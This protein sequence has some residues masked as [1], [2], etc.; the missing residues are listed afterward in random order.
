MAFHLYQDMFQIVDEALDGFVFESVGNLIGGIAPLFTSLVVIVCAIWGYR[1]MYGTADILIQ[2]GFFK[3]LRITLILT[4]GLT[5]GVY[6][7][8]IV[9]TAK[10]S[11][12]WIASTLTGTSVDNIAASLDQMMARVFAVAH[13]AW[14]KAGLLSG[15][16]GMY[17]IALLISIGGALVITYMSFLILSSKILTAGMLALGPVF[18]VLLLFD[19]TKKWFENWLG[20][21]VNA[22]LL[23]IL[24]TLFGNLCLRIIEILFEKITADQQDIATLATAVILTIV[25]FTAF[26]LLSQVPAI[27]AGLGGGISLVTKGAM[28]TALTRIRPSSLQKTHRGIRRDMRITTSPLR[29]LKKALSNNK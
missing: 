16:F 1:M 11:G 25:F 23:L 27:A 5:V 13:H 12:T 18:F 28:N 22:I 14:E 8:L 15:D 6:M 21:V 24:A 17:I 19:A 9:T 26:M 20:Y 2:E 4:L 7:E 29:S 10:G 3:I